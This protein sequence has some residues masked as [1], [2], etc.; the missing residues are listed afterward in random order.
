MSGILVGVDGSEH[1]RKALRWAV[2]EAGIRHAPLTVLTV[3]QATA[4]LWGPAV[5]YQG[6]HALA[7][8]ARKETQKQTDEVLA[9]LG[10]GHSR[11][12]EV[13]VLTVSGIPAEELLAESASAD[14]IVVGSR[15]AG[16]F[17]KLLM[18]SVSSQVAYHSHVPVVV[19]PP[20][21]RQSL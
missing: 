6:D 10:E 4:G 15:G 21:N 19:V 9:E 11:P 8:Q 2:R 17:R 3:H 5:T 20:D 14:M 1:S 18:G 7:E 16:G 12:P 13:S